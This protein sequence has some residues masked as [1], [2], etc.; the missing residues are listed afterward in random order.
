MTGKLCLHSLLSFGFGLKANSEVSQ[1]AAFPPTWRV[2]SRAC[3]CCY[4]GENELVSCA[5]VCPL[6]YLWVA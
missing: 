3:V 6:T 2:W 4:S 1:R 5:S